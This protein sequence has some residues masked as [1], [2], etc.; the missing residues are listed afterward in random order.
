M[1]FSPQIKNKFSKEQKELLASL[2]TRLNPNFYTAFIWHLDSV[3]SCSTLTL[4]RP[5]D[6]YLLVI[7]GV[8]RVNADFPIQERIQEEIVHNTGNEVSDEN[9][10]EDGEE[11]SAA[12]VYAH[13]NSI[14]KKKGND[15][16]NKPKEAK[17]ILTIEVE[18][19]LDI[20]GDDKFQS[21]RY[22]VIKFRWI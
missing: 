11:S 20:A 1:E 12:D 15:V 4:K 3:A 13:V 10:G 2:K 9:G 14:D 6:N 22:L 18:G 19:L 7:Q 16:S 17:T 5:I 21:L 8:H